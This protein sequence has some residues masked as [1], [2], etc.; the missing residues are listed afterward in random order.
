MSKR[1][2]EMKENKAT[3]NWKPPDNEGTKT[4]Y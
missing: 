1:E 4:Q 2:I 3:K